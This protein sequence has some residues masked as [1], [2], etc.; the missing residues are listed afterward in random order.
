M[1]WNRIQEHRPQLP[2]MS[3]G[4]LLERKR[5]DEV[6]DTL[7]A[8]TDFETPFPG[9]FIVQGD[10]VEKVMSRSSQPRRRDQRVGF[11][12]LG[13]IGQAV[14][15]VFHEFLR[16]PHLFDIVQSWPKDNRREFHSVSFERRSISNQTGWALIYHWSNPE[17]P[18]FTPNY[19]LR[20]RRVSVYITGTASMRW[21][22]LPVLI[23]PHRLAKSTCL[24]EPKIRRVS[25]VPNRH[26]YDPL[27][28]RFT[29]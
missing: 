11:E 9:L 3:L 7:R 17:R 4:C 13:V 12:R 8:R 14:D 2:S 26:R 25:H 15:D 5:A 24:T 23:S 1:I 21:R 29:R 18:A 22:F 28:R 6:G 10:A 19:T 27:M 16:Q 20:T